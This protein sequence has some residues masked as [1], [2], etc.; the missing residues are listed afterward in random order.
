MTK[1]RPRRKPLTHISNGDLVT[2]Q[3]VSTNFNG[4]PEPPGKVRL[5][6]LNETMWDMVEN[7]TPALIVDI[8]RPVKEFTPPSPDSHWIV[9]LIG[10]KMYEALSD[11]VVRVEVD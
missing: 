1:R 2:V 8:L 6:A 11:E 3:C 5:W 4:D 10:D 9:I 7:G